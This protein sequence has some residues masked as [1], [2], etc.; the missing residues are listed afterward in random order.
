MGECGVKKDSGIRPA[1]SPFGT[2]SASKS[3]DSNKN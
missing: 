1:F 3:F 2:K